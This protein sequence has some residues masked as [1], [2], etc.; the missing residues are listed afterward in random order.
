MLYEWI[1]YLTTKSPLHLKRMGY[2][3]E[4]IAL[5]YKFKRNRKAWKPHL[6]NTKNQ[7][8]KIC[9]SLTGPKNSIVL[10]G[11]GPLQD[12]PLRRLAQTFKE[13]ILIDL[14]HPKFILY[15]NVRTI[16]VDITNALETVYKLEDLILPKLIDFGFKADLVISCNIFSQLTLKVEDFLNERGKF[17]ASRFENWKKHIQNNHLLQLKELGRRAYMISDYQWN[18]FDKK[19]NLI[20]REDLIPEELADAHNL[21]KINEWEWLNS[22][23]GELGPNMYLINKVGVYKLTETI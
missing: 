7:I 13:V 22:P 20:E 23:K 3:H 11:S 4:F 6:T 8:L 16:K 15:K 19:H 1:E 2:L 21:V 14:Y 18:W 10:I 17:E 9:E 5:K 12:I